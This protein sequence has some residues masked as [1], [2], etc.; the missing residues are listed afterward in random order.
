VTT[1]SWIGAIHRGLA[2]T[3]ARV[4]TAVMPATDGEHA[5]GKKPLYFLPIGVRLQDAALSFSRVVR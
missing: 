3:A 2:A 5:A 4:S 1:I